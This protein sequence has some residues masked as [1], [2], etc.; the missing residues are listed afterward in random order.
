[1]PFWNHYFL[2]EF[3]QIHMAIIIDKSDRRRLLRWHDR[4]RSCRLRRRLGERCP[5]FRRQLR[6]LP[7]RRQQRHPERE[8]DHLNHQR[9]CLWI[10]K[11]H[12]TAGAEGIMISQKVSQISCSWRRFDAF[13]RTCVTTLLA[14]ITQWAIRTSPHLLLSTALLIQVMWTDV[15]FNVLLY[16]LMYSY[17]IKSI[18]PYA[19]KLLRST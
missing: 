7:R 3:S 18:R 2:S 6:R 17:H 10:D 11:S 8:G 16:Y 9:Y 12:L 15:T 19:R 1:M 4:R 14:T 5:G 13:C